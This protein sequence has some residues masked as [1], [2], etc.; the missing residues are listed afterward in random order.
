M[1]STDYLNSI[2]VFSSSF[3]QVSPFS[4]R[5]KP[6][7]TCAVIGN[8]GILLNSNCGKEIDSYDMIFR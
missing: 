1:C 3:L 5:D 7:N 6:Y 4:T 8:S 2:L